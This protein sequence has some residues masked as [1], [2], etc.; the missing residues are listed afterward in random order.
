MEVKTMH[1]L[2]EDLARAYGLDGVII[3]GF[4][5]TEGRVCGAR[6]KGWEKVLTAM[7]DECE[8]EGDVCQIVAKELT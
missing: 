5:F 3:L 7:L 1:G 8:H 2:A 6:S 4:D